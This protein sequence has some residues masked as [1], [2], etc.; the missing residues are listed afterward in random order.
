VTFIKSDTDAM[1]SNTSVLVLLAR[2]PWPTDDGWKT[3]CANLITGLVSQGAVV[4]VLSFGESADAPA[5]TDLRLNRIVVVPRRRAY[6]PRDL[7]RGLFTNDSFSVLNYR[8]EQFAE[9]VR[10][11]SIDTSYDLLLVEDVVMAQYAVHS[12]ATIKILDMH[13]I[14]SHLLRRFADATRHIAKRAYAA[15]TAKKLAAYEEQQA[16]A[17]DAVFVCSEDDR[18][19]L[20][21]MTTRANVHVVPNG[22]DPSYFKP[23][24]HQCDGSI[25]FVGNM[26]YHA[27]VSGVDYFVRQVMPLI[28]TAWPE[29]MF[30]IVGKNPTNDVRRLATGDVEVTGSVQDVRP[31]IAR[32]A[33]VV[34]PLLV[35][36]GT[37]LKILE[38]MAMA[39]AIVTTSTGCEGI[40]VRE[41]KDLDIADSADEMAR[42][43]TSLVRDAHRRQTLGVT[44]R[45]TV[46]R[47]YA[48]DVVVR[49]AAHTIAQTLSEKT[50]SN[51][52]V[53]ARTTM[54]S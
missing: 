50:R 12:T 47:T 13:N 26:D 1:L 31:Y 43:I 16:T 41:G 17:F 20:R 19:R 54:T 8:D 49:N 7:I 15:I 39:K 45:E 24:A 32:A 46:C 53:L 29:A 28:R 3:R 9:R 34:V 37:R 38:A 52:P 30:R 48:W 22:V 40:D 2:L 35:G 33:V 4:D 25:V 11:M 51:S 5:I 18:E 14:E 23:F 36:G 6:A 42:K 21:Q 44:A 27:N 10:E